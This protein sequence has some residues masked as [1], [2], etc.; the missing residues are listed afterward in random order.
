MIRFL[1]GHRAAYS[2]QPLWQIVWH[3]A[4]DLFWIKRLNTNL[5]IGLWNDGHLAGFRERVFWDV[6]QLLFSVC[7]FQQGILLTGFTFKVKSSPVDSLLRIVKIHIAS[8]SRLWR[9]RSWVSNCV[10]MLVSAVAWSRFIVKLAIVI[11]TRWL[12]GPRRIILPIL[13]DS[14]ASSGSGIARRAKHDHGN[15]CIEQRLH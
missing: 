4:W 14:R 8:V 9:I 5:V 11:T 1:S 2:H 3:F 13:S 7:L 12:V 15:Q 10:V 6:F